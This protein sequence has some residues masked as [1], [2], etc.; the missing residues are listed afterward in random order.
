[1]G[2]GVLYVSYPTTPGDI[3]DSDIPNIDQMLVI[4]AMVHIP[5]LVGDVVMGAT[6]PGET[7][8]TEADKAVHEGAA[9]K[10]GD[11]S[12]TQ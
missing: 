9:R 2:K 8:Q 7:L 1:M 4:L 11:V 6:Q 5:T 12:E 10:Q 3:H